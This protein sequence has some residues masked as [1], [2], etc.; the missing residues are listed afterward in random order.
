MV[1]VDDVHP[2]GD[3]GPITWPSSVN[4]SG[5]TLYSLV[6]DT[7]ENYVLAAAAGWSPD[8]GEDD[9][10]IP[11]KMSVDKLG[12]IIVNTIGVPT[13]LEEAPWMEHHGYFPASFSEVEWLQRNGYVAYEDVFT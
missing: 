10:G 2:H 8:I 3:P 11:D 5:D 1:S 12:N 6:S 4:T 9:P 13:P 7:G